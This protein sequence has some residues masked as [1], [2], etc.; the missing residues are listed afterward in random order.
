MKYHSSILLV[1]A[2]CFST[3]NSFSQSWSLSWSDEFDSSA[4]NTSNW[5]FETGAGG[6]GNN[7]LEYYTNRAV[8]ATVSN[9]N[10]LII[11]RKESYNGSSYTSARMKTQGLQS[12][13]YGKMEAR[14]KL[15]SGKGIWPAFW[16]LGENITSVGWPKCGEIDIMEH[17]NKDTTTEGTMHWDNNGH[18]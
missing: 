11:A 17:V 5:K 4:I 12:W 7:E 6:W 8:N 2:L 10:L 9:G 14:I 3:L 13:T 16:M 1:V 15:P 18:A